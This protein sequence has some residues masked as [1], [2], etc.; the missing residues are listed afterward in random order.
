MQ[1]H[2][3]KDS[4]LSYSSVSFSYSG[5]ILR[6]AGVAMTPRIILMTDGNPTDSTGEEEVNR[7]HTDTQWW[8]WWVGTLVHPSCSSQDFLWWDWGLGTG[9]CISL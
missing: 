8:D 6:I 1:L 3:N 7:Q 5:G 4:D 9:G 2:C